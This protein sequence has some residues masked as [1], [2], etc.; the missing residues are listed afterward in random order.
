MSTPLVLAHR[1]LSAAA[2][3]NTVEA[4]LAATSAG[5]DGI[6]LDVQQTADEAL[7][8]YHDDMVDGIPV[9]ALSLARLRTV[10]PPPLA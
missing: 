2:P 9:A 1:G 7:V 10:L 5:A 6:E 3:E 8:V 4:F